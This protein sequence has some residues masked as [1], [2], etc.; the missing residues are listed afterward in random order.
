MF[1]CSGASSFGKYLR[2][3]LRVSAAA[4]LLWLVPQVASAQATITGVIKDPSGAVL[5]GVTVE[6]ASPA[7][8]EKVR[9]AISDGS[10]QY[11]IIDLRPGTYSVSFTLPGFNT[12]QRTGVELTGNFTA[13]VNAEM[14][15]GG[16]EES[17]TVTGEAPVVDVQS[18]NRQRVLTKEVMDAIPSGRSHLNFASL[19]P[20]LQ[21]NVSGTRGTLADVGGTNNLQNMTLTMHGGRSFD[22]RL[23]FDGIRVGNAGS[24]GEFTNYVPDM[25]A[26]QELVIDYAAITAEQ[27]TGGVRLNYVPKD[28]GNSLSGMV[29]AT[30]VN[31]KFQ[32]NNLDEEL[33][34]R[35]LTAPN[36]MKLTYD[37][38][39]GI[40]GPIK[41]DKLWFFSSVR[42]Q[43]NESYVAGG[44][45]NKLG[46]TSL[47]YEPD[48]S[49][50]GV[51]F[52]KQ[53]NVTGRLT[54]QAN[55]ANKI[56]FYADK[57]GRDWDDARPIHAPEAMTLWRF[58]KLY[59]MQGG[60]TSTVSN[61]LLLEARYQEKAEGYLDDNQTVNQDIIPIQEQSTGFFYRGSAR[62]FAPQAGS[63]PL[64]SGCA[65][66]SATCPTSPARTRSRQATATHGPARS[67]I[68]GTSRTAS[69][70]GSTTAFQ[71]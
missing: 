28:G 49:Q 24:G 17:V 10:G 16:L 53:K 61:K 58:P 37:V 63:R 25:G 33:V 65:R 3:A 68:S 30:G 43:D 18:V 56:T 26:T 41:R 12:L 11:P 40:G 66:G 21:V 9:T 47:L 50:Q 57:Q 31:D 29:F 13:T 38:N 62:T 32:S 45:P 22:T 36:K 55:Q 23:M 46:P 71:T 15:V 6:A 2:G 51:F 67:A 34:A 5:P 54:Y 27:M 52:T 4:A 39:G 48:T 35:G 8:I 60:W 70:I 19:V 59:L 14:R 64:I 44:Y 69:A 20:G 1:D 42:F 7:L